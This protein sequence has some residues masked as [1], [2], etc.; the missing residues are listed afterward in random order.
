V[1]S[2]PTFESCWSDA[3]E[4][5]QA[6]SIFLWGSNPPAPLGELGGILH[7]GYGECLTPKYTLVEPFHLHVQ[8]LRHHLRFSVSAI[9]ILSDFPTVRNYQH[10]P[11]TRVYMKKGNWLQTH[12]RHLPNS[13]PRG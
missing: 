6:S 7:T 4:D 8:I 1:F 10:S 11:Q 13:V 9:L 12:G 3:S 2:S 5:V